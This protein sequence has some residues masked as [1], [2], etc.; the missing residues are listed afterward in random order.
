MTSGWHE[1]Y[2]RKIKSFDLFHEYRFRWANN[3]NTHTR[4]Q[5]MI[6]CGQF[7]CEQFSFILLQVFGEKKKASEKKG[8]TKE[9]TDCN[10]IWN[11]RI[12][13]E[14]HAHTHTLVYACNSMWNGLIDMKL[15][16]EYTLTVHANMH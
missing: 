1:L 7:V 14:K 3:I 5:K 9:L 8:Q 2:E 15:Q 4:R 16:K 13:T 6:H 12:N 11:C 10:E